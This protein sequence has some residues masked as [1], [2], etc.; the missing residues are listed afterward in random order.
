MFDGNLICEIQGK[1][2]FFN[3]ILKYSTIPLVWYFV[4]QNLISRS[5]MV[6]ILGTSTNFVDVGF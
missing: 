6:F 5:E 3:K 4:C 2:N 1:F